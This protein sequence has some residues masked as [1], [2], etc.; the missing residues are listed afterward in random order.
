MGVEEPDELPAELRTL[1]AR[2]GR[3]LRQTR[4]GADLTSSHYQVLATTM[5][6][7]PLRLTDLASL[8]GLNPTML[9]RIVGKLEA[10]GLVERRQ[11]REDG[12]VAHLAVTREG[13]E[14]VNRV[15]SERNDALSRALG[16]LDDEQRGLLVAAM[17]VLESLAESL[18]ELPR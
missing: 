8:E 4:A 1:I 5:R 18:A 17:P 15:R 14:L 13:R 9:S 2:L 3:R 16:G 11:D 6:N 7:G 12:R 10:A